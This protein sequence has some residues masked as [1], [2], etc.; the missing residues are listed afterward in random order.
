MYLFSALSRAEEERDGTYR[1]RELTT[2]L[3]GEISGE[4]VGDMVGSSRL[5]LRHGLAYP[6][7]TRWS[8]SDLPSGRMTSPWMWFLAS[9]P[10]LCTRSKR[11]R[12]RGWMHDFRSLQDLQHMHRE[13]EVRAHRVGPQLERRAP[14]RGHV[15]QPA[16]LAPGQEGAAQRGGRGLDALDDELHGFAFGM[17]L[18]RVVML[19]YGIDDIRHF[20]GGNLRFLSQFQEVPR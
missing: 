5:A 13:L 14:L 17:G 18:Q 16:Q 20:M 4:L 2:H 8:Q 7:D 12:T 3:I 6:M 15:A 11:P 10:K 19:R 1:A 9:R